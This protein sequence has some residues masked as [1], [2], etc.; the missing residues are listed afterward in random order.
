[1]KGKRV[2]KNRLQSVILLRQKDIKEYRKKMIKTNNKC[3][4]K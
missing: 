4:L 2:F 3:M 1:M